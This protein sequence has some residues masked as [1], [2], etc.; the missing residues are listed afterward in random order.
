MSNEVFVF[1]A[2]GHA[3]VVIDAIERA[4]RENVAF[5]C[6]DADERHGK[7]LMGYSIV[8]GRD[9]L[10]R[11]AGETRR[12]I[13]G[14]GDNSTR[15][16]VADWLVDHGYSFATVVHP[17]ASIAREVQIGDGTVIFA[18]CAVNSGTRIGRYVIINTG[19]TVDHDC[20]IDDGAH[21][22]P[23]VHLCGGVSIGSGS[24]VG[25][26]TTIIPGVRIGAHVV[27]GAGS[28]V[29]TD[30]PE[31]ARVGGSPCRPLQ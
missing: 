23:G 31:G 7:T 21:I 27:I 26:G 12:G 15:A 24:L 2:S 22:A 19:A 29:L 18:A 13:I 17:A 10:L 5:V 4:G 14:I 20:E 16:H 25:A 30:I 8:G 1:G 6:D 11:R 3:K 28:T 9:E